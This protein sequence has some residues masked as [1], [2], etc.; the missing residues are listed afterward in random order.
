MKITELCEGVYDNIRSLKMMADYIVENSDEV[1]HGTFASIDLNLK[2]HDTPKFKMI[3]D[4][5]EKMNMLPTLEAFKNLKIICVN[6]P[7]F[8]DR[9]YGT[10]HPKGYYSPSENRIFIFFHSSMVY[11]RDVHIKNSMDIY[12]TLIHELRHMVQFAMF[13]E[14]SIKDNMKS[15]DWS[16]K[17]IEWDS[18][19]YDIIDSIGASEED[20]FPMSD[21]Y[22][23]ADEVIGL[24]NAKLIQHPPY[25]N[26]P[27]NIENH[28]FKKALNFYLEQRRQFLKNNW[29]KKVKFY[30]DVGIDIYDLNE[31]LTDVLSGIKNYGLT[32]SEKKYF[33]QKTIATYRKLKFD[34]MKK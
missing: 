34:M 30:V 24:M 11:K 19:F 20:M 2:N 21:I 28:Y 10:T 32:D 8:N 16:D 7:E 14:F 27:K 3:A 6:D 1:K 26:L 25:I 5:L 18:S 15:G 33:R 29:K 31:F 22:D 12:K 23:L 17:K 4:Y 9:Y 13:K